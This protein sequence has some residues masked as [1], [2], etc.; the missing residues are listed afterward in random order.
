M[1]L[2][3]LSIV[4]GS[5]GPAFAMVDVTKEATVKEVVDKRVTEE[6]TVKEAADKEVASK[7]VTEEVVM[8]EVADK[9]AT[10][11]RVMEEATVKESTDKEATNKRAA[12]EAVMKE[13][14]MG[15][16]GGSS[17]SG[18]APSSVAGAKR[19]AMSSCSTPPAKRPYRGAGKP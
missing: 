13:V 7:R 6:A 11:K 5:S 17:T 8:K 1:R 18:Q 4:G 9:E 19:A 3:S 10:D 16:V 14:M 2:W 15:A 12:E